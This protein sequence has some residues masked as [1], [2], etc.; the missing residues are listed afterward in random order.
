[1]N[2]TIYS[3]S[4]EVVIGEDTITGVAQN[5][6]DLDSFDNQAL[7]NMLF[8]HVK[9]GNLIIQEN[10]VDVSN[11]LAVISK[12]IQFCIDE[13]QIDKLKIDFE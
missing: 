8:N 4:G 6:M 13:S 9:D 7:Y 10:G 5:L 12:A 11:S 1:M 2:Y 3:S